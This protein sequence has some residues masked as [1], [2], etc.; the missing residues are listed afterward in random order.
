MLARLPQHRLRAA[1]SALR[2]QAKQT[3][4]DVLNDADAD[5]FLASGKVVVHRALGGLRHFQNVVQAGGV[6]AALPEQ[7][8]R[9]LQNAA[10]GV[11]AVNVGHGEWMLA[12]GA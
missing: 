4:G 8:L 11:G 7:A 5:L 3:S 9:G 10:A 2:E 12:S 6:I 1:S